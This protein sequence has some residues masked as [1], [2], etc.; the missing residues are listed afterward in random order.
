MF[1]NI[2]KKI[3][4]AKKKEM[5]GFSLIELLVSISLFTFVALI[6]VATLIS[7]QQ[8]N[9]RLKSTRVLYD[10]L[11][12]VMDQ[13]GRDL[14]EGHGYVVN[15][16]SI[17]FEPYD[18]TFALNK[19]FRYYLDNGRIKKDKSSLSGAVYNVYESEYVTI[20]GLQISDFILQTYGTDDFASGDRRHPSVKIILKGRTIEKPQIDFKLENYITQRDSE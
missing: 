9:S 14:R 5:R 20:E 15:G 8:L 11:Y 10:N 2:F 16:N 4:I 7:T 13:I 19:K 18:S 17:E 3:N 6:A 1:K 12:L